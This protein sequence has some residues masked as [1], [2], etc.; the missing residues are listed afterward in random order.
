ME[1][2]STD[3]SVK[4]NE[5]IAGLY[6]ALDSAYMST[7][8]DKKPI[9]YRNDDIAQYDVVFWHR[10]LKRIYDEPVEIECQIQLVDHEGQTNIQTTH[11]RKTAEENKWM[12]DQ[13]LASGIESGNIK[14][15]PI[16]WRYLVILPCG[17]IVE[18]GTKDKTTVFYIAE[19]VFTEESKHNYRK[20]AEKFINTILGE[21]ERL[22]R[23]LF[24]PV[25]EFNNP[26]KLRLYLLVNV[27]LSN[28][29]SAN[30]MMGIAEHQEAI[31]RKEFLKYDARTS[32]SLDQEKNK[33]IEQHML[34]C[35][36]FFCSSISY[37]FMALEGF[38]NLVYHAFLK[39]QFRDKSF[40]TE[41]RLDLEQKLRYMPSLCQG[42]DEDSNVSSNNIKKFSKLKKYRNS[43]FHSNVEDS[44]K[45]LCFVENGF[46]Y[47]YDMD[48]HKDGFLSSHKIKLTVQ[49]V[50]EVKNII[51]D[52]VNDILGSM[53]QDTK[54]A[55]KTYILKEPNIP[56]FVTETGDIRIG[57]SQ[58]E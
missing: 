43:L 16:N 54:M 11:F 49:D 18:L 29:Q 6:P 47:N 36:M 32:D 58:E 7:D 3:I 12:I 40:R 9:D 42:F 25:K 57:K 44:L 41:Q 31:L 34:T 26:E 38:I 2:K 24:N 33:H 55:A 56:F 1:K 28:Y 48:A 13:T 19:I 22:K 51:D 52:L 10:L 27:Y 46:I 15:F 8:Y 50:I 21:A 45:S 39:Q 35:G 23:N 14:P 37:F 4:F 5:K 30:A 17:G 53:N 20:E